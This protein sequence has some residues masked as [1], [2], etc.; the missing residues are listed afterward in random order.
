MLAGL[1]SEKRESCCPYRGNDVWRRAEISQSETRCG[2]GE[3]EEAYKGGRC[4]A[5]P[6]WS[7][8]WGSSLMMKEMGED[9]QST[10]RERNRQKKGRTG[11]DGREEERSS[12]YNDVDE[13]VAEGAHPVGEPLSVAGGGRRDEREREPTR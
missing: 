5:E 11:N 13:S 10:E 8:T 12:L 2:L 4:G 7:S 1:P 6:G 9:S 3:E